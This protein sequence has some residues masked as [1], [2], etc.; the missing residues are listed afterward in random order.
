MCPQLYMASSLEKHLNIDASTEDTGQQTHTER[1]HNDEIDEW[2]ASPL[3]GSF[4][5]RIFVY[6]DDT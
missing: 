5:I 4:A 2:L 6:E 1:V 3:L